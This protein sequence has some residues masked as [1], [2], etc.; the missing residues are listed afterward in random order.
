MCLHTD[1]NK[2]TYDLPFYLE[3]KQVDL[4]HVSYTDKNKETYDLPFYLEDKQVDL[5]H[6]SSY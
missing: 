1:N 6:V 3:D 2:E 5:E 4:E